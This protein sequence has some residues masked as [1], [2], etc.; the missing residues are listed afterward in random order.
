MFKYLK[1]YASLLD[2]LSV[3]SIVWDSFA[4]FKKKTSIDINP[5][6]HKAAVKTFQVLLHS[7]HG[8]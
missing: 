4:D 8:L 1:S 3:D 7:A 2:K 5:T 6:C